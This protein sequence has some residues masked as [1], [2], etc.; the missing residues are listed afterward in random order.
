MQREVLNLSPNQSSASRY[1][2]LQ[3]QEVDLSMKQRQSSPTSTDGQEFTN[4]ML[5]MPNTLGSQTIPSM[6]TSTLPR[7]VDGRE[8]DATCIDECFRL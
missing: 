1:N 4:D 8:Y 7:S 6:Q 5:A 2:V 3:P